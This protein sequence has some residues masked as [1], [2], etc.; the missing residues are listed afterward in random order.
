[1]DSIANHYAARRSSVR[2]DVG[3]LRKIQR[4]NSASS[5]SSVKRLGVQSTSRS[6]MPAFKRAYSMEATLENIVSAVD[7]RNIIFYHL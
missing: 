4:K 6:T 3:S 1:M 2:D 5:V 7:D